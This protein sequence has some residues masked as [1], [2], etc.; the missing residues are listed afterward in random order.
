VACVKFKETGTTHWKS[1][2]KGATNETGFTVLPGGY[3]NAWGCEE[4]GETCYFW[5]TQSNTYFYFY[6]YGTYVFLL[7]PWGNA[8]S[9]SLS[10]RC[11]KD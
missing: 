6:Y 1:P 5:S 11:I 3:R 7:S 2:N 9:L 10:V 4:I 8:N